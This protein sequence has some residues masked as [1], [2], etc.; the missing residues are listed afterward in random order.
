MSILFLY[1]S[2]SICLFLCLCLFLFLSY[3]SLCCIYL[4]ISK[5]I[6]P[7]LSI[8][9]AWLSGCLSVCLAVCLLYQ[10]LSRLSCLCLYLPTMVALSRFVRITSCHLSCHIWSSSSAGP[11]PKTPRN[12][13]KLHGT[14][15]EAPMPQ[16]S[17]CTP[18]CMLLALCWRKA[19]SN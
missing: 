19:A 7:S 4:A 13:L 15:V 3:L 11:P 16:T 2:M 9:S 6:H 1:M 14:H 5:S 12:I 10:S 17:N 8:L 18:K